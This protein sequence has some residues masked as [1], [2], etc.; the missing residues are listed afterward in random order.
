MEKSIFYLQK[1]KSFW[2]LIRS[3]GCEAKKDAMDIW[4]KI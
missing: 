1:D 3:F 2:G 4:C